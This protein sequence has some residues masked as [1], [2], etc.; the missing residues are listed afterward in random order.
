[1]EWSIRTRY[2]LMN[3]MLEEMVSHF[4]R[5]AKFWCAIALN[6]LKCTLQLSFCKFVKSLKNICKLITSGERIMPSEP[7][8]VIDKT[9]IIFIS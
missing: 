2:S 3:T 7:R 5:A 4:S 8:M 6:C 9:D 1:M